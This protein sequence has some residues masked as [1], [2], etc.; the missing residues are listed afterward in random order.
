MAVDEQDRVAIAA[1]LAAQSGAWAAGDAA[2]FGA[3]CLPDVVFTNVVGMFSVGIEPFNALHA[4]IFATMYK[5]SRMTQEL[6]HIAMPTADVAVVDTLARLTGYR[7]A[8]PGAQP[9]DGALQTR[10]EQVMVRR[11]GGWWV[12]SFH[13][14]PVNPAAAAVVRPRA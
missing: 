14:V 1:I 6:A 5:G 8:P 11:D 9:I 13:N 2:A 10:L 3:R 4:H 12:Q 7:H